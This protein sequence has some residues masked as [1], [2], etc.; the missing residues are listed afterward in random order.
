MEWEPP[1]L[2]GGWKGGVVKKEVGVGW[3]A[4]CRQTGRWGEKDV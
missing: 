4:L 1:H 2:I 3:G